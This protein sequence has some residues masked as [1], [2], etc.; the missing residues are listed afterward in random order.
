[1]NHVSEKAAHGKAAESAQAD[2]SFNIL[3]ILNGCE[4]VYVELSPQLGEDSFC[5]TR[6]CASLVID[7]TEHH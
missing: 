4:Q 1:M 6:S 2:A 7:Y 3:S 5:S